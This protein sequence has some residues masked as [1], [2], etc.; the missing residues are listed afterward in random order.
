MTRLPIIIAAALFFLTI[1]CS[2]R[3]RPTA[4]LDIHSL[5]GEGTYISRDMQN[6][7][8]TGTNGVF[9][10][11]NGTVLTADSVFVDEKSGQ[12]TADGKVHIQQGDQ[13]WIGEHMRYNFL[14]HEMISDQYRSGK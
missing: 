9:I 5:N 2:V 3:A 12:A 13:V 4:D 11:Y 6:S 1:S 8:A 10:N 14:T 7:T